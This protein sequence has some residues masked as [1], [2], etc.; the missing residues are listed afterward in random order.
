MGTPEQ[1][2]KIAELQQVGY[3]WD[4]QLSTAYCA[5]VLNKNNDLWVF[6]LTGEIDHN[7]I[8]IK[9]L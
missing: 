3:K 4:K 8:S 7:P 2:T 6:G 9:V 5:V 1:L